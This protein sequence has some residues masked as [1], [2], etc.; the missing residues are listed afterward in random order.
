MFCALRFTR[1]TRAAGQVGQGSQGSL[2]KPALHHSAMLPNLIRHTPAGCSALYFS[3]AIDY[4]DYYPMR[5][6]FPEYRNLNPDEVKPRQSVE[7]D[8]T[9]L[10]NG[11]DIDNYIEYTPDELRRIFFD[12]DLD[13]VCINA[14]KQNK[15][16]VCQQKQ[17]CNIV[18]ESDNAHQEKIYDV[19]TESGDLYQMSST[20]IDE[21]YD[22]HNNQ[23][24]D[25]Q[26]SEQHKL[27]SRMFFETYDVEYFDE[28]RRA[29]YRGL[30]PN[31]ISKPFEVRALEV[32]YNIKFVAPW[33]E[34]Q[35][36]NPSDYL[37]ERV[38]GNTVE[39]YGVTQDVFDRSY[40]I[41][42][43]EIHN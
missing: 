14:V 41:V 5:Y 43:D 30:I 6:T 18:T 13:I 8:K 40:K 28:M 25:A 42:L 31:Y 36:L 2:A 32:L 37:I 26:Y 20:L 27:T 11:V 12:R 23:D 16:A 34:M 29:K 7:S 21:L 38:I 1:F 9:I 39:I 3:K 15:I 33:G 35:Y 24:R 22:L 19:V 17:M 10:V 4:N